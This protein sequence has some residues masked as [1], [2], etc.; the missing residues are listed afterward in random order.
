MVAATMPLCLSLP[1]SWVIALLLLFA[2]SIHGQSD[3]YYCGTDWLDAS[4]NCHKPCPS[5]GDDE[6]TNLNVAATAGTEGV[7]YSCFYFTG[8][9]FSDVEDVDD[10]GSSPGTPIATVNN[11]CGQSWTNAMLTCGEPCPLG[12]ECE[13]PNESCFA[14]TNCDQPLTQLVAETFVTLIGP[15]GMMMEQEDATIFKVVVYESIEPFVEDVGVALDEVELTQQTVISSGSF[16]DGSS[17]G[18]VGISIVVTAEYRPPPSV[19]LGTLVETAINM[20][21]RIVAML[22]ERG[23]RAGREYFRAVNGIEAVDA[24]GPIPTWFPTIRPTSYPSSSLSEGPPPMGLASNSEEPTSGIPIMLPTFSSPPTEVIPPIGWTS[25]GD[26]TGWWPTPSPTALIYETMRE[27]YQPFPWMDESFAGWIGSTSTDAMELCRSFGPQRNICPIEAICPLG[28]GTKPFMAN[29]MSELGVGGVWVPVLD[30]PNSWILVSPTDCGTLTLSG[31]PEWDEEV[32]DIPM[33][34]MCCRYLTS[35]PAEGPPPSRTR[36]PS[37]RAPITPPPNSSPTTPPPNSVSSTNWSPSYKPTLSPSYFVTSIVYVPPTGVP[38]YKP[39]RPSPTEATSEVSYVMEE[40]EHLLQLTF[41]DVPAGYRISVADR[42][43]VVRFVKELL[44]DNLVEPFQL[45]KV[46]GCSANE[47][48]NGPSLPLRITVEGPASDSDFALAYVMGILKDHG[49]D[50][51]MFLKSLNWNEFKNVSVFT[52]IYDPTSGS[53]CVAPAAS[54]GGPITPP[55]NSNPITPPPNSVSSTNWSPSYKPTLSPS[56]FVTSIVNVP[57]TGAPSY[58]LN[59]PSPTEATSEGSATIYPTAFPTQTRPPH[60][61]QFFCGTSLFDARTNCRK[62]CPAG[63][64]EE[65]SDL[66]EPGEDLFACYP[67]TGCFQGTLPAQDSDCQYD[68]A[69]PYTGYSLKLGTGCKQYV[70]CLNGVVSSSNTCPD[71]TLYN[72]DVGVGG[73]CDW[74]T[75]VTCADTVDDNGEEDSTSSPVGGTTVGTFEPSSAPTRSIDQVLDTGSRA[76]LQLGG[77]T[78]SSYGYIFNIRTKPDSGVVIITGFD[79][80]TQSTSS[81]NF[82]LWTRLGTFEGHKGTF[83][84]WDLIASGTVMGRGIGRYTSIPEETFTPVSIPGGAGEDGTRAFYLTLESID[85]VYKLVTVNDG[86]DASMSDERLQAETEDI[87]IYQG[88]GVLFYPFPDPAEPYYYRYPRAYLG[89]IHYNRLPCAPLSLYGVVNEL[90]CPLV[91]TDDIAVPPSVEDVGSSNEEENGQDSDA[92]PADENLDPTILFSDTFFC[93]ASWVDLD[94]KCVDGVPQGATPCPTGDILDCEDGQGCFAFACGS[95]PPSDSVLLQEQPALVPSNTVDQL[96][97]T[98]YCG[99]SIEQIDEDCENAIP[100][101]SGD[102]CPEGTGC[103][104]FSQCGGIDIDSLDLSFDD[105][106]FGQ[107]IGTDDTIISPAALVDAL[108]GS[109]ANQA[110]NQP[111]QLFPVAPTSPTVSP[112]PTTNRNYCG[113]SQEE[114]QERCAITIPCPDGLN[115]TCLY[116]QACFRITG[117]CDATSDGIA[118]G[119]TPVT[120]PSTA[121]MWKTPSPTDPPTDSPSE[122]HA[123]DPNAIDFCGTDYWDAR[124]NCHKNKVCPGGDEECPSGQRCFPGMDKCTTSSPT[125]SVAPTDRVTTDNPTAS[126][127]V[128]LP[129]TGP[130][131]SPTDGVDFDIFNGGCNQLLVSGVF[132][133]GLVMGGVILLV[134]IP[135]LL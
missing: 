107:G 69:P 33:L 12:W 103:L 134:L 128:A 26:P 111:T 68:G 97:L 46:Y 124:D 48:A 133:P 131:D 9:S 93:A 116:G 78:T 17:S 13:D 130:T 24:G 42:A 115:S 58:K 85:L 43:S 63:R 18:E 96:R 40:T 32:E 16:S 50:I 49:Q 70:Y 64:H 86:S 21:A 117:P 5:G 65:C 77:Q 83:E 121:P 53:S 7:Q 104:A 135:C 110:I 84:G 81:V 123:Y 122:P 82:E 61:N 66:N 76:D 119:Y 127:T 74:A 35:I 29:Q 59:T 15:T 89:A 101:P 95:R 72:G 120:N 10:G 91:P 105:D 37:Y 60:T 30:S 88:E 11:Y 118:S 114:A 100:C 90:P 57:S 19:D 27:K 23:E 44:E 73:L 56:Y 8:C 67:N 20:N 41:I 75:S 108:L 2:S 22:R 34:V 102:E 109:L 99:T 94:S 87:S 36:S 6:C 126:P 71:E 62:P 125:M 14:A 80:Y 92:T 129:T 55:P 51:G 112:A 54:V 132:L 25:S 47:D 79:F 98:F 28:P 45:V 106:L 1:T 39:N 4:T 38:S 113:V 3:E 52:E 31:P